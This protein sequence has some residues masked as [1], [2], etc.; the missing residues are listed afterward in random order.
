MYGFYNFFAEFENT[1]NE[2]TKKND[3]SQ[4]KEKQKYYKKWNIILDYIFV[5]TNRSTLKG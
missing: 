3:H 5:H 4:Y 1:E 2:A